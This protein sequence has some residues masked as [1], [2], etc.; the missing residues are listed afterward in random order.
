MNTSKSTG[1]ACKA[2][3]PGKG[4]TLRAQVKRQPVATGLEQAGARRV[5]SP[6]PLRPDHRQGLG[7]TAELPVLPADAGRRTP[8][9]HNSRLVW[10][11]GIK[12]TLTSRA[13]RIAGPTNSPNRKPAPN[14]P[15]C[16]AN[17]T[18][19]RLGSGGSAEQ[20]NAQAAQAKHLFI[21]LS[22]AATTS[23]GCYCLTYQIITW[24]DLSLRG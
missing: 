15:D 22:Q 24:E 13:R 21:C 10:R 4:S 14:A 9:T 7:A 6:R 1:F 5:G 18:R 16:G 19:C 23:A 3:I 12:P 11:G 2:S 20:I 8:D 17:P